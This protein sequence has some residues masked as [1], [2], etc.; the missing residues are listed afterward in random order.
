MADF[1]CIV[2]CNDCIDDTIQCVNCKNWVHILCSGIMFYYV[3]CTEMHVHA[4]SESFRLKPYA[5]TISYC[6]VSCRSQI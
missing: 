3:I 1:P 5:N 6:L 2:C 4:L